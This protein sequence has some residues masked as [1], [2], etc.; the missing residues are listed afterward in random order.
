MIR[1]ASC[2]LLLACALPLAAQQPRPAPERISHGNF[3][4]VALYR[5][6]G[7]LKQVVLMLSGDGGW[8][9]TMDADAQALAAN[10]TFVAGIDTPQMRRQFTGDGK[11][12]VFPDGD[13][14]NLSHYLQ[15]YAQL[16]GYRAPLLIGEGSG[17]AI[18]YAMVAAGDPG[19]FAGA[20]TLDF[21]P[22]LDLGRV[23]C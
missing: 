11:G 6:V 9:A 17:A 15:G 16:P 19:I 10:G 23:P 13:L 2:L 22:A 1:L 3:R 5:P 18:A 4:D 8:N 14:E 21:T 20:L 12:C 7:P